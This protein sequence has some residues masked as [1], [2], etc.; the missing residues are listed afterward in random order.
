MN[1]HDT[2]DSTFGSVGYGQP[3]VETRFEKGQSGNPRGRPKGSKNLSTLLR[4]ELEVKI[5]LEIDGKKQRVSRGKVIVKTWVHQAMKG[6][7]KAREQILKLEERAAA[8]AAKSEP[9]DVE[10][11]AYMVFDGEEHCPKCGHTCGPGM[12]VHHQC[13][14]GPAIN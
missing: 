3:P 6:N 8:A 1:H 10:Y 11:V 7:H 12:M 9:E 13:P 4:E 2:N 5:S 14:H